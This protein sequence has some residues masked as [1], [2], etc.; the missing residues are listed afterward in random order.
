MTIQIWKFYIINNYVIEINP[1]ILKKLIL[2][3]WEKKKT[4]K[5]NMMHKYCFL[6]NKEV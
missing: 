1:S 4:K 6:N 3:Y 5:V 2:S